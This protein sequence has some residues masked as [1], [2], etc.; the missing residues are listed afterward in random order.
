VAG[1]LAA[2]VLSY[3]GRRNLRLHVETSPRTPPDA[4][5]VFEQVITAPHSLSV[6]GRGE[7]RF[8]QV[9]A[10]A[11]EIIVTSDS[12]SMLS[13]TLAAGR[14]VSIY[15]LPQDRGV[16]WRL[17]EWLYRHAVEHPSPL[18]RPV[19]ALF[20]RGVIEPA[21]DRQRLFARLVAEKRLVWFGDAPVAPDAEASRRDAG[22]ALARLRRLMTS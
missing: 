12:V 7:N 18:L 13:D 9:L 5:A 20:D 16:K 21:A 2:D 19:R 10:E 14:P 15:R 11:V 6:F 1:R 22:I 4:V 17:G 8:R 3:A